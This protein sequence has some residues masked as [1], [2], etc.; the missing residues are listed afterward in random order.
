MADQRALVSVPMLDDYMVLLPK[1]SKALTCCFSY[2]PIALNTDL[3]IITNVL[4]TRLSI[5]LPALVDVDQTGFMSGNATDTNLHLLNCR[6][7][8][9]QLELGRWSRWIWPRPLIPLIGAT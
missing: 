7:L 4:A 1:P 9:T 2:R 3:K 5:V 8:T 6:F